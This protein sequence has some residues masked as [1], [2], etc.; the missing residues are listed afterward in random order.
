MKKQDMKGTAKAKRSSTR[1]GS[2]QIEG[3]ANDSAQPDRPEDHANGNRH[4]GDDSRAR[5]A[6]RAYSMYEEQGSRHG[7][8]VEH[9][10]KAEQEV[11]GQAGC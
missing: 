10:L 11:T 7:Y 6:A 8:D 9:W 4:S 5:I 3:H 2:R 1:S